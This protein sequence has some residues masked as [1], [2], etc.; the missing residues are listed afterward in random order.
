MALVDQASPRE[1]RH[2]HLADQQARGGGGA[3]AI[4][5]LKEAWV[6]VHGVSDKLCPVPLVKEFLRVVGKTTMIDEVSIIRLDGPYTCLG[7][8]PRP[9]EDQRQF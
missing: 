6:R 1:E 7:L 9:R 4:S 3:Q 5:W 2:H 8:V